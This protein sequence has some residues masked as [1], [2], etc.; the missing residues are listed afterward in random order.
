MNRFE[1][2]IK[3]QKGAV[4]WSEGFETKR[5]LD[6]WLEAERS[7]KTWDEKFKVEIA[8]N[9]AAV[10]EARKK[11]K[12]DFDQAMA[13]MDTLQKSLVE[14]AG[15]EKVTIAE[16]FV[17]FNNLLEHMGLYKPPADGQVRKQK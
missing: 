10:D 5:E 6:K 13:R 9:T 8:D 14:F 12:D 1:V 2:V 7:K 16:L 4:Y 11:L 17:A 3:T 15:K